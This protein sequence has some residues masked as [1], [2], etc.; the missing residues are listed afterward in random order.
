MRIIFLLLLIV[1]AVVGLAFAAANSH[2]V[3]FNYFVDATRQPLSL[4]LVVA[5]FVGTLLGV[6]ASFSVVLGL[7]NQIRVLKRS[8]ATARQEILN[9][10]TMP[11][12]DSP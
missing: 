12:K 9:L 10:R 8:E 2:P 11:L 1:V 4:L 5:A 3:D 6:I 7:K